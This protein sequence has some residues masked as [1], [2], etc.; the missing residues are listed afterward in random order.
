MNELRREFE[1]DSVQ[2]A[3]VVLVG[4]DLR[5]S[6]GL[7]INLDGGNASSVGR[8]DA[9]VDMPFFQNNHSRLLTNPPYVS[10]NR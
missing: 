2:A 8:Y 1:E 7:V 5:K 9:R 3:V 10:G 4:S 6:T